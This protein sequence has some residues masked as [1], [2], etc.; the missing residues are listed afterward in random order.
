[1]LAHINQSDVTGTVD[2]SNPTAVADAVCEIFARRYPGFDASPIR[3]GFVDIEDAFWGRYPGLLPCDTPYHD[4][5]HSL[6][7]ALLMARMVDGFEAAHD[8]QAAALGVDEGRLAV[9][10]A[11]FHDIG[12]LRRES[13][14]AINGAC[15]IKDH[16]Q[17]GVDFMRGYLARGPFARF[18][19]Q[20]ALIQATNFAQPIDKTLAG[21]PD[22]LIVIGQML[23]TADLESQISGRYY[24]ERCR[25][26]LFREFV[27]A[28]VDRTVSPEGETV[29]LY[30]SP[31][32]LLRKTPGFYEHLVKNR[33]ENDFARVYRFVAA[34]FDGRDPYAE[35]MERNLAY[36]K[37]LI[38]RNDFSSLRRKPVPLMPPALH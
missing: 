26:F 2:L 35:A 19:D 33:L 36:L 11:L 16:E 9:L 28:G 15:L 25:D 13:E 14:S 1:M 27:I 17:R 38:A 5:R 8:A 32:D 7:T 30:A 37:R 22:K 10:L 6:G 34:H 12:F 18:A 3:Q 31:E 20:A 29:V 4:L 24:L 21:L 23:G